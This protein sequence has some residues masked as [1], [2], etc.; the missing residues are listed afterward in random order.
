MKKQKG[1][2]HKTHRQAKRKAGAAARKNKQ[3][4]TPRSPLNQ[5]RSISS[6]FGIN[7]CAVTENLFD[8]GIGYVVLGRTISLARVATSLFLVDVH[9]LGVKNAFYSSRTHTELRR[10]I[11]KLSGD[12]NPM[13]DISPECARKIVDGAVTYAREFGFD[14]HADFPPAYALFG[15]IHAEACTTQYE[16]GK[17]GMPLFVSGPNDTPEKIRKVMRSLTET[18]GPGN[19]DYIVETMPPH[20]PQFGSDY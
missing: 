8:L 3:T 14:P 4:A 6:T 13:V 10:L 19:F 5:A 12:G 16:F 20:E 2:L 15:D 9:C 18:A 7:Y 17:D 1:K 11:D